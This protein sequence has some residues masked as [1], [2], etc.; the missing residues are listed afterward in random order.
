MTGL[1]SATGNIGS[2]KAKVWCVT[3]G[4]SSTP[5][6]VAGPDADQNL[7]T[8]GGAG[9]NS[10]GGAFR[11][12]DSFRTT[13]IG[14]SRQIPTQSEMVFHAKR[15][16]ASMSS[17]GYFMMFEYSQGDWGGHMGAPMINGLENLNS[18]KAMYDNFFASPSSNNHILVTADHE[19]GGLTYAWTGAA[20]YSTGAYGYLSNG[21]RYNHLDQFD[22]EFENPSAFY[23]HYSGYYNQRQVR[24]ATNFL[25]IEVG[26]KPDATNYTGSFI[27]DNTLFGGLLNRYASTGGLFA[28]SVGLHL[29]LYATSIIWNWSF[30]FA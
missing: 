9:G 16:L 24:L 20:V 22:H 10:T 11:V 2:N 18:S 29:V 30:N 19:C 28:V 12:V 8:L 7:S 6:F 17:A 25:G 26:F 14:T 5:F 4:Y 21:V 23:Y 3:S 15:I 1:Q 27:L 13:N